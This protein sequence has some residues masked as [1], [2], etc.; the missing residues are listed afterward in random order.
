MK[1]CLVFREKKIIKPTMRFCCVILIFPFSRL[2]QD[3]TYRPQ[4]SSKKRSFKHMKWWLSDTGETQFATIWRSLRTDVF[5][6]FF[7]KKLQNSLRKEPYFQPLRTII[8]SNFKTNPIVIYFLWACSFVL[9]NQYLV[10]SIYII[11]T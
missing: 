6:C 7:E 5:L 11:Q 4:I 9:A 10:F 2:A 1:Y 8:S 3:G